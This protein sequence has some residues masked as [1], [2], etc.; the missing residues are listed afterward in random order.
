MTSFSR[1][2]GSFTVI[3]MAVG[4][5]REAL[6]QVGGPEYSVPGLRLS[7]RIQGDVALHSD[8]GAG[9][10]TWGL[11]DGNSRPM[12]NLGLPIRW[13]LRHSQVLMRRWDTRLRKKHRSYPMCVR[14]GERSCLLPVNM[15]P[16]LSMHSS[17]SH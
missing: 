10:E 11:N 2:S 8:P 5:N 17:F 16:V 6:R 7:S 3:F 4:R 9:G 14:V 13:K 12:G 1:V 15:F